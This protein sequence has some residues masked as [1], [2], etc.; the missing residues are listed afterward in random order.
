MQY[1]RRG[2]MFEQRL[3]GFLLCVLLLMILLNSQQIRADDYNYLDAKECA[4]I[5]SGSLV[6]LA[7]AGLAG[8]MDTTRN[9]IISSP[10]PGELSIS[11]AIGG[12]YRRGRSNFLNSNA[13]AVYT[14]LGCAAVLVAS[15]TKWPH[16]HS[17]KDAGED[18][19]V[20]T[21]GLATTMGVT[22]IFKGMFARP[23][24]YLQVD[25]ELA[26]ARDPDDFAEDHASFFSGHASSA[27]FSTVYLNKRIRS[28]MRREMSPSEYRDY[29]WVPPAVLFSWASF[30]GWSRIHAYEHYL[31]DVVAGSLVGW[32]IAELFFSFL[33]DFDT[34]QNKTAGS[35]PQM[36]F[37]YSFR[38]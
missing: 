33:D 38:F 1:G 34:E 31:S 6:S 30:V 23:R 19:F 18:L 9:S 25:P 8:S 14:P 17:M 4:L 27:F 16:D 32:A 7:L 29:R 35:S 36:I 12:K 22:G 15:N 11:E 13:G 2:K 10:L 3:S 28:I 26:D 24:P 37:R 5:G 20:F 21:S